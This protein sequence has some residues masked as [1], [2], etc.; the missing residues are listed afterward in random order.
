MQGAQALD[1][2]VKLHQVDRFLKKVAGSVLEQLPGELGGGITRDDDDLNPVV[3]FLNQA[4]RFGAVH[5][6][7]GDIE[8]H[9]IGTVLLDLEECFLA[10]ACG[11]DDMTQLLE[12]FLYSGEKVHFVVD[13]KKGKIAHDGSI[14]WAGFGV[15]VCRFWVEYISSGSPSKGRG[16]GVQ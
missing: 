8:K 2:F 1:C 15:G 6:R 13:E 11:V 14:T 12:E 3:D 5:M 4:Q 10:V 16:L 7:H 9:G